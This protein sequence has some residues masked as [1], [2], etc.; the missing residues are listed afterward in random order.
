[1]FMTRKVRTAMT[2]LTLLSMP[3]ASFAQVCGGQECSTCQ[4]SC[5]WWDCPPKF[6]YCAEGPPKICVMCACPK[7]VCCPSDTPNWGYFPR[8]W[9]PWPWAPNWSHC[10]G[11]PPASQIVPPMSYIGNDPASTPNS[12]L[13]T[14]RV[15]PMPH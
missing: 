11:T 15:A 4:T 9:R 10:Y 12:Q 6:K 7:P 14:P 3:S 2:V 8:C 13:P 5:N 1:M